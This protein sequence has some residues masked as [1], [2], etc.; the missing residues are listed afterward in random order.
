MQTRRNQEVGRRYNAKQPL[1][2][3]ERI[4]LIESDFDEPFDQP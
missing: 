1:E 2:P 3:D 4:D